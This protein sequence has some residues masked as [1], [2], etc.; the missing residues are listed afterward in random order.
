MTD[1]EKGLEKGLD[2]SSDPT[3]PPSSD[4]E[5]Q[6]HT[7]RPPDNPTPTANGD[8]SVPY[9]PQSVIVDWDGAHDPDFPQ[10]WPLKKKWII[11]MVMVRRRSP[12]APTTPLPLTPIPG[13]TNALRYLRLFCLQRCISPDC[14]AL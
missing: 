9:G 11:T 2:D 7:P 8:A 6:L 10:N 1:L 5:E 3:R 13:N 4:V 14:R 12:I